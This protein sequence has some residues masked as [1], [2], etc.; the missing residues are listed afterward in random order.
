MKTAVGNQNML[1][2]MISEKIAERLYRD[3]SSGYR[4]LI[5]SNGCEKN[6]Q[7]FPATAA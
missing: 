3:N 1:V 5:P 4:L 6:F 2:K 7:G